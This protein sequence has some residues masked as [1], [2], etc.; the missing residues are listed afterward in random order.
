MV[1]SRAAFL[2]DDLATDWRHAA[3]CARHS[4]R[5]N[6]FPER[7][8]SAVEAKAICAACPVRQ[9]CLEFALGINVSCGVWGGLSGRERRQLLRQRRRHSQDSQRRG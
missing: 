6:F 4:H 9:P 8:E 1:L 7:G 2:V 3:A 5:V